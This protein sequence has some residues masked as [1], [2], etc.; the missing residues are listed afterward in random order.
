MIDHVEPHA[1]AIAGA[2]GRFRLLRRDAGRGA[3][4]RRRRTPPSARSRASTARANSASTARTRQFPAH[5]VKLVGTAQRVVSGGW[6]FSSVIVVENSA[7]DPRV[8]WKP[9]TPPW[10]WTGTRR[11]QGPSTTSC[12]TSTWTPSRTAVV[13]HLRGLRNPEARGIQQP[14]SVARKLSVQHPWP[15]PQPCGRRRPTGKHRRRISFAFLPNPVD[16]WAQT[17]APLKDSRCKGGR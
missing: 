17:G 15:G 10:A 2:K 9:A 8:S 5:Q 7:P 12:R 13:E 6:L 1:D 14:A 4:Q 11:R 3:A 16:F